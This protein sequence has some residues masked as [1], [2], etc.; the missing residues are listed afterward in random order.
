MGG[1]RFSEPE[2]KQFPLLEVG[3]EQ[4]GGP[5]LG[6]GPLEGSHPRAHRPLA[7][8]ASRRG[9]NLDLLFWS[10]QLASPCSP[11]AGRFPRAPLLDAG[12]GCGVSSLPEASYVLM[13]VSPEL[14]NCD[15]ERNGR[16]IKARNIHHPNSYFQTWDPGIHTPEMCW[17]R[18]PPRRA[19]HVSDCDGN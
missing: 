1:N 19:G 3:R 4:G 5:R 12:A 8:R 15:E 18:R 14:W 9:L 6:K 16:Q 2:T 17:Q 10:L 7:P 11:T 13:T